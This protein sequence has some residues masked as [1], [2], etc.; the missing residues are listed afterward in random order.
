MRKSLALVLMIA[1]LVSMTAAASAVTV[2][3]A[4]GNV[5]AELPE[6]VRGVLDS[7]PALPTLSCKNDGFTQTVT[8]SETVDWLAVITWDRETKGWSFNA[9]EWAN[10]EHTVATTDISGNKLSLGFG[11]WQSTSYDDAGN[12]T[13][14]GTGNYAMPAYDVVLS[15]GTDVW[16]T[17]S[18]QP[19][20]LTMRM[21]GSDFFG[22]GPSVDTTVTVKFAPNNLGRTV[23]Y[24]AQ[25][26][27]DY[28]NGTSLVSQF[29]MN[30]AP[31]FAYKLFGGG[32]WNVIYQWQLDETNIPAKEDEPADDPAGG[33]EP[34]RSS[35]Q[36]APWWIK[37]DTP[38]SEIEVPE[39]GY[40]KYIQK[41]VVQHG[42]D[43]CVCTEENFNNGV[44]DDGNPLPEYDWT[45]NDNGTVHCQKKVIDAELDPSEYDPNDYPSWYSTYENNHKEVWVYDD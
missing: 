40:I 18:G 1:L 13:W 30:G 3:D 17:Q 8:L 33:D 28:R 27:E 41:I 36:V 20:Q 22:K 34:G 9:M 15:D 32:K 24:V 37:W 43:V 45:W 39:N 5:I 35:H 31:T 42:E 6:D 26:K 44:D 14:S 2:K 4:K 38:D 19:Y 7:I 10:D 23:P 25:I 12:V 16:Y 29:A 11:M 21:P